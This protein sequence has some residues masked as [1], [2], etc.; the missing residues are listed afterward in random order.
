MDESANYDVVSF[1]NIS[2]KDFVGMFGGK[3]RKFEAHSVTQLPRFLAKHFAYHLATRTLM[4]SGKEWGNESKELKDM[5][6]VI[7]GSAAVKPVEVASVPETVAAQAQSPVEFEDLKE[8]TVPE[9]EG[10]AC[11]NCNKTFKTESALK[12]HGTRFHKS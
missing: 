2:D 9:A 12:A 10:F 11:V 8:E 1:T 6:G 4:A 3:E 7:L 5:L